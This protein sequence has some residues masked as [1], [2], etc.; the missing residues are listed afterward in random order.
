MRDYNI[1]I[2]TTEGREVINCNDIMYAESEFDYSRIVFKNEGILEVLLSISELEYILKKHGFFRFN[3]RNLV[4]LRYVQVIFPLDASKVILENGKEIFV[5]QNK[6]ESL[7]NSLK[8]VFDLQE[9]I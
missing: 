8:E 4:N 3:N 2:P 7:F 5:N 9:V 6:K 1:Y